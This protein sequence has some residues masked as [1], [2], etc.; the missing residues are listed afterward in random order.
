[1]VPL[2]VL[3][4]LSEVVAPPPLTPR[5]AGACPIFSEIFLLKIVP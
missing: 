1:M 5:W 2:T 3:V 4:A